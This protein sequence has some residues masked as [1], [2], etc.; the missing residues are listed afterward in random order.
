M[1][2][3]LINAL[4]STR[5]R[6]RVGIGAPVCSISY[7]DDIV[8]LASSRRKLQAL[9]DAAHQNSRRNRYDFEP[10]KCEVVVFGGRK[11]KYKYKYKIYL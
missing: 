5:C 10:S 3:D 11:Y 8:L 9:L 6:I 4:R 7:A 2:A 1:A